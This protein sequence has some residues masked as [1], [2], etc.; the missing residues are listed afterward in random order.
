MSHGKCHL[1]VATIG[2]VN[3]G[4]STLCGR[5]LIIIK[6]VLLRMNPRYI[7]RIKQISMLD[8]K[9]MIDDSHHESYI[10][11]FFILYVC[12][13]GCLGWLCMEYC[14]HRL[15]QRKWARNQH[16]TELPDD[17]QGTLWCVPFAMMVMIF[18]GIVG[19]TNKSKCFCSSCN[20]ICLWWWLFF[21]ASIALI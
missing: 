18:M 11:T 17:V 9:K 21:D 12:W 20:H 8:T 5:L 3:S 6:L 1:T 2:H 4:K 15:L 10:I 14:S 7:L 16:L 19:A 13:S